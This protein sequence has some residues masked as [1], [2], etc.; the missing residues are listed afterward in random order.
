[1]DLL[2]MLRARGFVQQ[3]THLDELKAALEQ[4]PIT[5]YAGFDPTADS[6]HVGHL[7]Q[8]MLM[9][10]LQ[11]AGHV[12]IA[13]VGG[14][15]SQI[16]DPTGRTEMRQM[17][18]QPQIT[19]NT[20]RIKSQL[21]HFVRFDDGRGRLVDN[22]EWLM[23]LNYIAFLRDIGSN[24][25]VNRMLAAEGYRIRMERGLSFIELNYQI[26]QAYDFL[27]L[28][29]RYDCK[30]QFGGDDQWG[31][32]IAGVDLIRR[33]RQAPAFGL[34]TPLLTT[35]SGAKMGKTAAGAVWLAADRL[36]PFDYWQYWYN[37]DD[38][39]VGKLLRLYT[40]L[41]LDEI[42]RLEALPGAEIREAKRVL[43]NQVT[44]LL[45][46][47]EEAAK[48]DSA[49]RAMSGG[50]AADELPTLAIDAGLSIAKVLVA[51]GLAKSLSDARRLVAQGGVKLGADK[52]SDAEA[53]LDDN[54]LRDGAVLRV[55]KQKAVRVVA[56]PRQN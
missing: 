5:F 36:K 16:G 50:S 54:A 21:S 13:V 41:D 45:H 22:A 4:G 3:C 8:I 48:A 14:G 6:L 42:T 43:A 9:S 38:R 46:G 10:H 53:P 56:S 55:G 7:L 47:S 40:F 33:V 34:T 27:E 20:E 32:I 31:N 28:S 30:L 12:A 44:A 11:R 2:D 37:C 24:F 17:L 29:R 39:D 49:A 52:V 1:M 19:A 15:T 35:A 23:G 51:A 26:L 18:T 25:S